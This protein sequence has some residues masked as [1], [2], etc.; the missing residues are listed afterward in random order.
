M[1]LGTNDNRHYRTVQSP[2]DEIALE[3][4]CSLQQ[5]SAASTVVTVHIGAS[6]NEKLS[7][8]DIAATHCRSCSDS[9]S[10]TESHSGLR[11][12]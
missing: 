5:C 3:A 9:H 12:T 11:E 2:V 7:G 1:I 8:L 6:L 4:E 10:H